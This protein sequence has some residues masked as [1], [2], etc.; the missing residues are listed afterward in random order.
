MMKRIGIYFNPEVKTKEIIFELLDKFNKTKGLSFYKF[1]EQKEI[2]PPFIMT[3]NKKDFSKLDGILSF[4]GDGTF[5]R[6]TKFSLETGAPLLGI[7]LGK[8]GFLSESSI[9]ELE[10]SVDDLINNKFNIQK[11]MLLRITLKRH[12]KTIFKAIALNDAVIY[13]GFTPKLINLKFYTNERFVLETRS[14]G[15]IISTPTGS[16]AYSLSA[17]GP[18]I[19]PLIDAFVVTQ[20]NPHILGMR[21]MVFSPDDRLKFKIKEQECVLQLDGNNVQQLLPGDEI[22]IVKA[23]EK[24]KFIKLTNKTFYQI[25]RKKLYMGK[26]NVKKSSH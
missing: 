17:G 2:I 11:R 21:S 16:T 9:D 15:I 4:G 18:I 13:K 10:K 25:L 7:N 26:M 1:E 19:S 6:A 5:L 22:I 8:L 23:S 3:I 20:L 14:D 12:K 24:V